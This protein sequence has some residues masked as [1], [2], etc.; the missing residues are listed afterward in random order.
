LPD[1]EGPA[2]V[3]LL[4]I[5]PYLVH[6]YWD[7]P[8]AKPAERTQ[9]VLRVHDATSETGGCFEVGVSLAA[10]NRYIQLW[11]PERS[12]YAE[13]GLVEEGGG[14]T[15]LARSNTI[16]TPRAW[17]VAAPPALTPAEAPQMELPEIVPV[18]EAVEEAPLPLVTAQQDS[19]PLQPQTVSQ[20]RDREEAVSAEAPAPSATPRIPEPVDA[21]TILRTRLQEI[22]AS[23]DWRPRPRLAGE[24]LTPDK[25][26]TRSLASQPH[27]PGDLTQLAEEHF[28]A[29][30]SSKPP[31]PP[32]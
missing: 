10:R 19:V 32:T 3:T 21:P 8:S 17:P 11:T 24:L 18:A 31:K 26:A 1:Y 28:S 23:L 25:I 2:R 30:V 6:A 14:F 7:V 5:D 29:G 16:Q 13:L 15:P 9:A 4:V 22:Y 12:Y 27:E 20:N